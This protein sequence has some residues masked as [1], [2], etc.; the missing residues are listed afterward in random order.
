MAGICHPIGSPITSP[1]ESVSR[2]GR[3]VRVLIH[4]LRLD[5]YGMDGTSVLA[6]AVARGK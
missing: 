6:R 2:L 5:R 4:P 3:N 1:R